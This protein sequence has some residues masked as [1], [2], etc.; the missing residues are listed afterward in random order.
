LGHQTK[1]GGCHVGNQLPD[2][3]CSPGATFPQATV[4]E[5]CTP[6]YSASVRNVPESVKEDV[7]SEYGIE[8]HTPGSY[9][10]DH[11]IPLELGGN[12]AVANLWPEVRPGYQEKDRIE[13]RLHDAV[14]S[15]SVSLHSAQLQI[16]H[17]WRH[18]AAGVPVLSQQSTP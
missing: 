1:F 4:G 15:R 3:A 8:S 2:T 14:C 9:E 17:D 13:N 10:V 12:N 16:A 6:G 18:T 7:Y 11:L 5:I